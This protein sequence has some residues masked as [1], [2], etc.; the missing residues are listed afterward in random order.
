[1][2][3]F[4]LINVVSSWNSYVFHPDIWV[5]LRIRSLHKRL[6]DWNYR[7]GY[8]FLHIRI[9]HVLQTTLGKVK[10]IQLAQALWTDRSSLISGLGEAQQAGERHVGSSRVLETGYVCILTCGENLADV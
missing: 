5:F 4:T 7:D 3:F 9:S 1:M 2:L 10:G 8:I 6:S